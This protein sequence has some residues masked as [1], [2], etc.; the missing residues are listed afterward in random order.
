MKENGNLVSI[1]PSQCRRG[2]EADDGRK[3]FCCHKHLQSPQKR[4]SSKSPKNVF[5][6]LQK[7]SYS[8]SSK[9]IFK[10]LKK[11]IFQVFQKHLQNVTSPMVC[12]ACHA[13]GRQVHTKCP[14]CGMVFIFCLVRHVVGRLPLFLC[15]AFNQCHVTG[16]LVYTLC[17]ACHVTGRPLI[18]RPDPVYTI[19]TRDPPLRGLHGI[20]AEKLST[21]WALGSSWSVPMQIQMKH[22]FL[23]KTQH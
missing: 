16:W 15:F 18:P 23:W 6:L 20:C 12:P 10:V 3:S 11:I 5:K 13:T 4:S 2:R 1:D 7:R 8:K 17:P 9:N 21:A 14:V 22:T 19:I